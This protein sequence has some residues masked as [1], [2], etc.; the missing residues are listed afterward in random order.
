MSCSWEGNRRSGVTLAI[1]HRLQF[2]IHLQAHG[3]WKGDDHPTYTPHGAW[4][5]LPL[6]YIQ[7]RVAR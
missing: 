1:H 2:F 3:L 6:P 7:S 5:T 4:L